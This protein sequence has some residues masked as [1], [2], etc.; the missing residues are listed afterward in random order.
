MGIGFRRASY[1]VQRFVLIG[2]GIITSL[3]FGVLMDLQLWPWVAGIDTQLS[4]TP[5]DSIVDNLQ[6]FLIFHF[7]TALAWDIPRAFTT[8]LLIALTSIPIVKSLERARIKLNITSHA[9]ARKA[10]AQ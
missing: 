8:S 7:A 5:G 10:H 1:S 4:F 2:V 3:S 9:M 6:K